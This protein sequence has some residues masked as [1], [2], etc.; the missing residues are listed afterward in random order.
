MK[1]FNHKLAENDMLMVIGRVSISLVIGPF[2]TR[3]PNILPYG[4]K[5]GIALLF[6]RIQGFVKNMNKS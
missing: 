4:S 3:Q 1:L 6:Y 5:V 2:T